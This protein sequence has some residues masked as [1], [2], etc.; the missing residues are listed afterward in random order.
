M[1][2]RAL[3][4]SP[5][6]ERYFYFLGKRKS[7]NEKGEIFFRDKTSMRA[8]VRAFLDTLYDIRSASTHLFSMNK[9]EFWTVPSYQLHAG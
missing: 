1:F 5:H 3:A 4:K 8:C 7:E 9:V 6:L 2:I